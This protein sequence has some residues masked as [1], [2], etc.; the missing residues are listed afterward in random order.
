MQTG[1]YSSTFGE[2][3][4]YLI[5]KPSYTKLDEKGMEL[6]DSALS[7][8]MVRDNVTG[9]IWEVKTTDSSIHNKGRA[10]TWHNAQEVFIKALNAANFGGFS[11]WRLPKM[12]ELTS[13][14]SVYHQLI[15]RAYFP[16]PAPHSSPY[17]S[18][19]T[20]PKNLDYAYGIYCSGGIGK[21]YPK[22]N[23][24]HVRAVRGGNDEPIEHL[25]DN[26][27]GTVTD[28]STGLM[29]QQ[30]TFRST[31]YNFTWYQA[32]VYCEALTLSGYDD[33]RLPNIRELYSLVE[34]EICRHPSDINHFP[35]I[36]SLGDPGQPYGYERYVSSTRYTTG[37][38]MIHAVDFSNGNFSSCSTSF[39]RHVRAVRGGQNRL[40][41]N[42][43]IT[44]PSQAS[45]WYEGD[46]MNIEWNTGSIDGN[47]SIYISYDGGRNFDI[48]DPNTENDG[49]FDWIV[50]GPGSVNCLLKIESLTDPNLKTSQGLFTILED[51]QP[52]SPNQS[53]IIDPIDDFTL[54]EGDVLEITVTAFDHEGDD[55]EFSASNLP[56]GSSFDSEKTTFTWVP[57]HDQARLYKVCFKVS[58]GYS[59][60]SQVA[61]ISVADK[62][63][64]PSLN[65]IGDRTVDAGKSLNFTVSAED[66]DSTD[67]IYSAS[68]L[69]QGAVFDGGTRTFD[70]TPNY[71]QVGT[72]VGAEFMVSDGSLSDEEL[73]KITVNSVNRAPQFEE[74][75]PKDV[76]EGEKISFS[77]NANDP[78][79]D[80]LI[81]EAKNLPEGAEFNTSTQLFIWTPDNSQSGNYTIIFSV[82]DD[83]E[84]AETA[85]LNVD[86]YVEDVPTPKEITDEI[87]ETIDNLD[88]ADSVKNSYMA[89]MQ[90]VKTFI[91]N[92][93]TI[94]AKNQIEAFIKKVKKDISKGRISAGE[95]QKLIDYANQLIM[96]LS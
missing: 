66:P 81:Y 39:N 95:G 57:D 92:D 74:V 93:Q 70:W 42:L 30:Q 84:P 64:P 61:T 52:P 16:N 17:W 13:I 78:D 58:D 6:P 1:D 48:I 11:D 3:S 46:L 75:D 45:F 83:G 26:G 82:T 43:F 60:S 44:F 53:P 62:N 25:I 54:N 27:D 36:I 47:V 28:Y 77:V 38:N 24:I 79:G 89:N 68:N 8:V 90:S 35:D 65:P 4:D 96:A 23:S 20:Y 73:I 12:K 80:T 41:G 18:S 22:S 55:L 33:W 40:P 72:Y 32:L 49:S 50:S 15:D 51:S 14:V 7:W 5:N 85:I 29:W 69:P 34:H 21:F 88:L 10:Y 31:A 19:D 63:F 2:D 91:E 87:V 71:D 76:K 9:L 37:T 67:L 56:T 94:P 59:I 86:I